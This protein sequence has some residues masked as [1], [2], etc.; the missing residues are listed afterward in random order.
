MT[1][2]KAYLAKYQDYNGG[3][4]AFG[5]VSTA[6]NISTTSKP[7]VSTTTPITP[8]TTSVFKD[9]D[10]F[11]ADA[12]VM[13]SDKAKLKGVE[14]KEVKDAERPAR[15]V[16]T[17]KPLLK[18]DPKDKGKGVLEEEP[19]F[20]KVKSKDQGEAQIERDVKIAL[21][22]QAELDEEARLE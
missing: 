14:M 7:E 22:V 5:G 17:L 12:L 19:E 1:G 20:V 6:F 18:I 8:P 9:E 10:I 13:L 3:L 11:L 4:V 15:S 2:N 21:E 16:L